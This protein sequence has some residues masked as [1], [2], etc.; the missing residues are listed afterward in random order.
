VTAARRLPLL[1]ALALAA[2]GSTE[3]D[4]VTFT[5]YGAGP[6]DA[7]AGQPLTFTN[8][9]GWTVTLDRADL[10]VGALY[11]NKAPPTVGQQ[12][13]NCVSPG[14]YTAQVTTGRIV[15]A[16]DPAPQPFPVPGEGTSEP[17]QSGE[18]WLTGGPVDATDD[19]TVI[20]D[21]AGTAVRGP[22]VV[23]FVGQVTIGQNRAVPPDPL[24]PGASPLCKQRIVTPIPASLRLAPGTG[25]LVRVDPRVWFTGVDFGQLPIDPLDPAVRR[26]PDKT[27][28]QPSTNLYN[29]L[30]S[31]I[32]TYAFEPVAP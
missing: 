20:A 18:V 6:A 16:L 9:Q 13:S 5:A 4:L 31:R 17:A 12:T 22:E 14:L 23:A 7:V 21:F 11:L 27:D 28:G 2:C 29:G 10:L 1:A 32:G 26:F 3:G 15:D 19:R 8:Q 25:L 24:R 30:R